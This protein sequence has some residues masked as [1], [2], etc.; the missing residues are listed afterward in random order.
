MNTV[1]NKSSNNKSSNN[2]SSNM[3]NNIAP[4]KNQS[5]TTKNTP[6]TSQPISQMIGYSKTNMVGIILLVVVIIAV[7]GASYWLYNFYV[8]KNTFAQVALEAMPDIKDAQSTTMIPANT[9]PNSSY[10]NEYSISFW[11]NVQDFN[12]N[13]GKEKTILRRGD[14]GSGNP[15]IVLGAKKNDI[16]IRLKLQGAVL[17]NIV[18][19]NAVSN[20]LDIPIQLQ[21]TLKEPQ[22]LNI[23]ESVL[24]SEVFAKLGSNN[25]DFPTLQYIS[26]ANETS[27]I[28][29]ADKSPSDLRNYDQSDK[30]FSLISGNEIHNIKEAFA[31][32]DATDTSI[33]STISTMPS[34]TSTM[35]ST[36]STMPSTTSANS[37]NATSIF[38]NSMYHDPTV[39]E[40][41]AK[42]IPL[43][44]WVN[45]IVSVYNQIIDI[46]IDGQLTSSCIL[47]SFPAVSTAD[48][49][50]TPDG[51]FAGQIGRISFFNTAMTVKQSQSIYN[52]GP[53][54]SSS[55]IDMIPNW[56]YWGIILI[57]VAAIA[58]SFFA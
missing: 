38:D 50:I 29:Q 10:S 12:Y 36:T 30:Y 20:F 5:N 53:V 39:G 42:M 33:S 41:S 44:K 57:M 9:I 34:T 28:G 35:P 45:V 24:D 46:Y 13:Y 1:N 31:S 43:Q 4:Q 26:A 58:Y 27:V 23:D 51:G 17:N 32:G 8:S 16:I 54:S 47:K 6:L 3:T 18:N 52:A 2:K 48:I 22:D 19:G 37:V 56:V 55:I 40:C 11:I 14:A 25:I 15:E 7:C 21:T 49:N